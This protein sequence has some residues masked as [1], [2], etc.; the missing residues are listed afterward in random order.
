MATPLT[1]AEAILRRTGPNNITVLFESDGAFD[2]ARAF[3]GVQMLAEGSDRFR[4]LLSRG[5]FG[6]AGP[7][8]WS[9]HVCILK[10]ASVVAADIMDITRRLTL[11]ADRPLWRVILVNPQGVGWSGL[12]LHFDHAI[13]DGTR[14]ARHLVANVRPKETDIAPV[15][16]MPLVSLADLSGDAAPRLSPANIGLCRLPFTTLRA[17]V[18]EAVSHGDALLRLGRHMLDTQPEFHAATARRKDHATLA[19]IEALHSGGRLGNHAQMDHIDLSKPSVMGETA[20]FKPR[21]TPMSDRL[22]MATARVVPSPLLRRI[23]Q[24]EFSRPG[25]VQTI[26]PVSRKP[27]A[28]FGLPLAAIHPAAP[29]L[30]RPMLAITAA[31][32]GDGFDVSITAHTAAGEAVSDL[33]KRVAEAMVR[34]VQ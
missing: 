20:L 2:P 16:A 26:V 25:I 29:A 9:R 11:P 28:L 10:D 23:V 24:A 17:A 22:R 12:A 3:R 27:V 4:A 7:V 32:F 19:R 14:I 21:R 34:A 31:R 8:D 33:S 18:P 15:D 13:A 6:Q 5:G 30:G 1:P